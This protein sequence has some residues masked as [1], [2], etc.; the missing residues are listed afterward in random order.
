MAFSSDPFAAQPGG[1]F[2]LSSLRTHS[3]IEKHEAQIK[4]GSFYLLEKFST[5]FLGLPK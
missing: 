4:Q 2:T 3:S 1:R 5:R